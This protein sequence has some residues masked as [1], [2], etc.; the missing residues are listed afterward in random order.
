M[1]PVLGK[2]RPM[3]PKES[4]R[5]ESSRRAGESRPFPARPAG[6]ARRTRGWTTCSSAAPQLAVLAACLLPEDAAA[7]A[8]R[9]R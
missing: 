1:K 7:S 6:G 5:A 2:I 4:R 3:P 8:G 9:W